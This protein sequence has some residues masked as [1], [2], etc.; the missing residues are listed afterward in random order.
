MLSTV[1]VENKMKYVYISKYFYKTIRLLLLGVGLT[2]I[3]GCLWYF[4]VSVTY[5]EGEISF[6]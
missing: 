3:L 1:S 2:Y 5:D 4:V 6:Y